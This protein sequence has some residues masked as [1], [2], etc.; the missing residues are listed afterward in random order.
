MNGNKVFL[1]GT[2]NNAILLD[3]SNYINNKGVNLY[4][5]DT[6][7]EAV[8]YYRLGRQWEMFIPYPI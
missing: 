6:Y 2:D 7:L 1:T 3:D 5:P 4:R 8:E